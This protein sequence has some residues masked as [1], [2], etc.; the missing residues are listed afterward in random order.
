M[1]VVGIL[2]CCYL[3]I[4][5]SDDG[6]DPTST[7]DLASSSLVTSELPTVC[8]THAEVTY[9]KDFIVGLVLAISSSA[10][11]GTSFIVKKKGLLKLV[12]PLTLA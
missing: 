8:A 1:K 11:I 2:E 7:S 9:S 12:C 3:A 4:P 5:G 6:S 10:F